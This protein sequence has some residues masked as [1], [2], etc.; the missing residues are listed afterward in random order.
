MRLQQGQ[1]WIT[2]DAC[3][4]IV[5]WERLRIV[6]KRLATPDTGDGTLHDVSKK[7]FCRLIKNAELIQSIEP[8]GG[9]DSGK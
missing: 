1:L 4:R 6:Y 2:R 5:R 8:T 7:E 3:L 9:A